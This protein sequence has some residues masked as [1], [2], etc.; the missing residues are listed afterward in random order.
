MKKKKKILSTLILLLA[1]V[2]IVH[3]AF[4]FSFFGTGLSGFYEKG[5][6]G[7]AIGKYTIGEEIKAKYSSI[8]PTSR[9]IL[10]G[11]WALLLILI[12]SAVIR[13]KKEIKKEISSIT[14]L[15]KYRKTNK[16]TKLDELYHLLEDK[17]HLRLSTISKTFKIEKE[18]ALSW[19]KTLESANLISI[20]YSK[21]GEPEIVFAEKEK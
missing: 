21:F 7:F 11:E 8:S 13:N 17:K 1:I 12:V 2:L 19:A 20:N 10:I 3:N 15:K 6:S 9:I 14:H 16:S 5:V 18:L 4:H